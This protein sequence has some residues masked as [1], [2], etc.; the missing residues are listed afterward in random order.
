MSAASAA[1]SISGG[2]DIDGDYC[3]LKLENWSI[4]SQ[5]LRMKFAS[6]YYD[7]R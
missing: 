7:R 5:A 4:N 3:A 1:F 2:E 6:A